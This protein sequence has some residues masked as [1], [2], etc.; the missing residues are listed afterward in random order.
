MSHWNHRV[1]KSKFSNGEECYSVREIH[2]NDAGE[3]YGYTSE[4]VDISGESIDAL[5]QYCKWILA[6]LDKPVLIEGEIVFA[7]D[8]VDDED[9]GESLDD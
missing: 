3:I 5:K 7:K 6:C 1:L 2:Y 4:P 8:N 9:I